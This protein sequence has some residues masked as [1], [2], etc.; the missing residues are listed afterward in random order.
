MKAADKKQDIPGRALH[1]DQLTTMTGNLTSGE[2]VPVII[3][4]NTER[5]T[6]LDR[7]IPAGAKNNGQIKIIDLSQAAD[8]FNELVARIARITVP[9]GF[10]HGLVTHEV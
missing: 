4:K 5:L 2:T 3:L 1:R 7:L 6:Q 8:L 10:G 9:G